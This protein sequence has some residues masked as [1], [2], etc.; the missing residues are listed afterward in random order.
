MKEE[1]WRAY[2]ALHMGEHRGQEVFNGDSM[3]AWSLFESIGAVG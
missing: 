2:R 3:V 1:V